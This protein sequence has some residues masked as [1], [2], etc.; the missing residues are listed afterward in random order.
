MAKGNFDE[1]EITIK[2]AKGMTN[3]AD[4]IKHNGLVKI[5]GPKKAEIAVRPGELDVK[6][7]PI[8][9]GPESLRFREA[10]PYSLY[11]V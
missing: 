11:D 10:H 2:S 8:E 6:S 9:F 1:K 3:L 7:K 4:F 5:S